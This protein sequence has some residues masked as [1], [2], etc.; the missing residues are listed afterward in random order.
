MRVKRGPAHVKR[1]KS[2]L[3]KTKGYRWGRKKMVKLARPAMLHAGVHAYRSRRLKKRSNRTLWN[4]QI[5]AGARLH[6]ITYSRFIHALHSA[7]IDLDR[8]ILA[9]LA[10]NHPEIFAKVIAS[11]KKS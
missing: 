3:K 6:D 11:A 1:R 7:H 4:I 8:K 10:N 5:N 2:L 9:E